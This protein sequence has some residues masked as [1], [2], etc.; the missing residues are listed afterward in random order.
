MDQLITVEEEFG[1][2]YFR[3]HLPVP[4]DELNTID[5]IKGFLFE[6]LGNQLYDAI[7]DFV[8]DEGAPEQEVYIYLGTSNHDIHK[9]IYDKLVTLIP[10]L[11]SMLKNPA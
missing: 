5:A 9:L 8:F 10:K 7:E 11:I 6:N 2:V 4:Y 3:L 1:S